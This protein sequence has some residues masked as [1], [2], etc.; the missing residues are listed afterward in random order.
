MRLRAEVE[1]GRSP[2]AYLIPTAIIPGRRR[3][4]EIVFS[5]HLDHPNPGA[6]DNASGCAGILEVARSLDRLIRSGALPPARADDPLHLA[7]RDRGHDRAAQRPARIRP[8]DAGDDPSRHDRRQYRDHQVDAARPRLAAEPA[9]LRLRR[10][11]RLRPL[12]QRAVAAL[13]RHRRAPISRWSIRTATGARCRP[14]SAA[15]T[16]GS[17]HQVWAEGSWRIPVIYIADWPDRYIH[18]QRDL[19]GNLD[20][21]K[22]R[23]AI[24]IAAGV[25]LASGDGGFVRSRTQPA[26]RR[27]GRRRP[28]PSTAASAAKGR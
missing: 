10:R 19:P 18:T 2:S 11:L 12:R 22:M 17:D 28:A 27:R 14:R 9:E 21:T 20:P 25:G 26:R 24:F 8:A 1:A 13:R 16:E 5:C 4:Q 3:D 15:S 6:N 23:R 7:G